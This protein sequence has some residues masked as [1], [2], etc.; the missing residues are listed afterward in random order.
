MSKFDLEYE[1]LNSGQESAVG[2]IDGPLLVIAGP[3]TGKTQL[4]AMR[5]ANILKKTDTDPY[6]ILCLTFTNKAAVNMKD[7][8]IKLT[9]GEGSGVIVKTFHSFA[10]EVMNSYPDYFWNSASLSVAPASVQL[11][12]IESIVSELPLD[13]PLA[14]KFAGQ[15]TLL[16]DIQSSINLAKD[17]GLTPDKL[18]DIINSNLD[19]IDSIKEDLIDIFSAR[20]SVK[21]LGSLLDKVEK[22]P[23]QN[24]KYFSFPLISFKKVLTENL[25][26]S[27]E[28]DK[29][30]NATKNTG[31][32]K[33]KLV[34]NIGGQPQ[35]Y[36]EI[37]RN[38]WWL[39]L[40]E[41][42]RLYREEM[43]TR[44]FYDYSDMLV[45]V[46]K[47]IESNPEILADLQDKYLYVLIDEFQDTNQAQ[48]KIAQMVAGH[49]TDEGQPNLMAVGDDD[50]SIFKFNGAELSNTMNFKREYPEGNLVVLTENFR[51]SQ[52]VLDQSRKV[53][54]L[55]SNRLVDRFPD[56]DKSLIAKNPPKEKSEILAEKYTSRE[57][58][59]SS[60]AEKI[61]KS[62][63]KDRNIAVLARNH[64]SLIKMASLLKQMEVPVRYEQQ[65]N[66]LEHE[67]VEQAYLVIK[68]LN[69]IAEGDKPSTDALIHKIIRHPMWQ[70]KPTEL[71][72]LAKNNF[73][74]ADWL[75]SMAI[76]EDKKTKDLYNW[77]LWLSQESS[78][79]PLAVTL[80]YILGLRGNKQ[81][82]SPMKE[83]FLEKDKGV[84]TYF[85]G[86]SAIQLLRS[87]VSDFSKSNNPNLADLI[88]FFEININNRKIIAD[89][90]PFVSGKDSVDLLTVH[91]SKGLEFDDV[92]IVDVIE[93]NWQPR[94]HSRKPPMNLPL[95]PN[96]D[97][98]DDFVRLLYVAIT[99]AKQNVYISGFTQDHAGGDVALSPILLASFDVSPA[100]PIK[101]SKLL[102]VL[103]QHLYWPDL[104]KAS[105]LDILK[106]RLETYNLSVTDLINFLDLENAG[107]QYF[108]ER[109]LLR[110]P[111]AKNPSAAHGTAMHAAMEY[112]QILTNRGEFKL[113]E[114]NDRYIEAL[115]NENLSIAEHT[116]FSK[117][118]IQML[119]QLFI[120]YKYSLV[121]GA[122]TEQKLK[123]IVIG[124]ARISGKLDLI[125]DNDDV[126]EVSDYKT[127]KG[128]TSFYSKAQTSQIK[129]WRYKK[130]LC[131]YN[132]L[133]A[134]SGRL[135]EKQ[136]IGKM[137][138]LE[139]DD[140]KY[141]EL[142]YSPSE[143]EV[144]EISK[145]AQAGWKKIIN[146]E[147]PDTSKYS[148]DYAGIQLF[149][150][151]LI[152]N[153]I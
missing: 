28:L 36:E 31:A 134:N 24:E 148:N 4:L 42:Y 75:S 58:Q 65:S 26:R 20:L 86:L 44:G 59:L 121:K 122:Q 49:H 129:S 97:E 22:L 38:K 77:F 115:S 50:Q 15:Y 91:K 19:Y 29:E 153:N 70:I 151:D 107:P 9:D 62:Y 43:H 52:D 3:G 132:L 23:E 11:D 117:Q 100:K 41:V 40:A 80:E 17:A 51:S 130:Q 81:F 64:D 103:E 89:E 34:Q 72:R 106:A 76:T 133:L 96:G 114:V 10:A 143:E 55:A 37:K 56:L 125:Y 138:F 88:R 30:L 14:L 54:E 146:L 92:Y 147:L 111:E 110:L 119:D 71:W 113:N 68:L 140:P 2:Q 45:E 152:E 79:Q 57:E 150:K 90:S 48:L 35:V 74:N 128:I 82:K 118:G 39:E 1:K 145:L 63:A 60:V 135:K 126:V 78:R 69:S 124:T 27:I 127:G 67:M 123:D 7:R 116:R 142:Q 87:L 101:Q 141:L 32:L 93:K 83:Y 94:R 16:N 5:V 8:I 66:I 61:K 33:K 13:N 137:V 108:K 102:D 47:Q 21:S 131:F 99:R 46:I 144:V 95:L 109:N 98:V 25:N 85:H 18:A 12:V 104:S 73:R 6:S 84:G 53:I 139:T 149:E 112:A 120:K 136:F 105:E